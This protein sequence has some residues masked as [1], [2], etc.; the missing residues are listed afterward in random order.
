MKKK[1]L[2]ELK[3]WMTLEDAARHLTGIFI[4]DIT[5]ADLLRL[6]L[7]G[8]IIISVIFVNKAKAR[9]GK[10]VPIEKAEVLYKN[11]ITGEKFETPILS[12][13]VLNDKDVLKLHDEI[14][15]IG[16]LW[17]LLMIGNEKLDIEQLY[18][19]ETDGPSIK[20][21][22]L[23]GSFVKND[24]GQIAQIQEW[25]DK[26]YSEEEKGKEIQ[27]EEE[28]L[29]VEQ[30]KE[31]KRTYRDYYPAGKLPDDSV[32]VIR[33]SALKAFEQSISQINSQSNRADSAKLHISK[34]LHILNEAAN[35][36]WGNADRD[37]RDTHPTNKNVVT[38]LVE[39]GFS[40][41]LAGKAAT[42]IRPEWAPTGRKPEE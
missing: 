35:R 7:D 14:E 18:Q 6:S 10:V 2:F 5:K 30:S 34:N 3:D 28:Q 26:E 27:T 29:E 32:F 20:L 12:G 38:W 8:H 1:S 23:P 42:I 41:T 24:A 31:K 11:Y 21:A 33:T 17:D 40:Q 15:T 36:F 39:K 16:G 4:E 25:F 37:E 13:L 19:N 22:C 9:I